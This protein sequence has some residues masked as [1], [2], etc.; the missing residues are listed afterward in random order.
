MQQLQKTYSL[1]NCTLVL[2]GMSDP[3]ANPN[4]PGAMTILTN[5]VCRFLGHEQTLSGGSDFLNGLVPAV[6]RY[7]QEQLSGLKSNQT[8]RGL[9]T[10]KRTETGR[11]HLSIASESDNGAENAGGNES[12]AIELTTVQLFDLVEAIDQFLADRSTLPSKQLELQPISKRDVPSQKPLG[13]KVATPALGAIGLA[14]AAAALFAVEVPEIRRPLDDGTPIA[15]ETADGVESVDPDTITDLEFAAP[16][17]TDAAE[18]ESIRETVFANIDTA[19]NEYGYPSFTEDAVYRVSTSADGEIVGYRG[20]DELAQTATDELPLAKL[21]YTPPTDTAVSDE[22]LAQFRVTFTP[23][24]QL[25]VDPWSDDS[26]ATATETEESSDAETSAD[27]EA[28]ASDS[29]EGEAD[30]P[31]ADSSEAESS[32]AESSE[33][34]EG[35]GALDQA[36]LDELTAGALTA[37]LYNRLDQKWTQNPTFD[38]DLEFRVKVNI[39]SDVVS[40]EP[41]SSN[42]KEFEDEVPLSELKQSDDGSDASDFKV[43]FKSNGILEVSPWEGDNKASE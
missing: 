2:D 34:D 8:Q 23:E 38:E 40:Y 10:L 19:W 42:A 12:Q 27:T 18:L 7:A 43:V 9:V 14:V 3:A 15:T 31:E 24:G 6:S 20:V 13:Q 11:H 29:D 21:L 39:D 5:A 28:S 41:I 33:E 32:E 4:T 25:S 36:S 35:S 22:P 16:A 37:D 17:I 30:T 1:P 26:G